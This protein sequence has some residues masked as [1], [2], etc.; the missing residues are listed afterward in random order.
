MATTTNALDFGI[1]SSGLQSPNTEIVYEHFLPTT[2]EMLENREE[3]KKEGIFSLNDLK[4]E[5]FVENLQKVFLQKF[6]KI[7]S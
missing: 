1:G 3:I 7:K 5:Q 2:S 4:L 6:K